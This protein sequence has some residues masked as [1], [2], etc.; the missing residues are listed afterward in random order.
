MPPTATLLPAD[1]A[2]PGWPACITF[3]I[4]FSGCTLDLV[5]AQVKPHGYP[6]STS[7]A[8]VQGSAAPLVDRRIALRLDRDQLHRP[9]DAER[10]GSLPEG[11]IRLDQQRPRPDHD[12]LPRL[13]RRR[14]A[15]RRPA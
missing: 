11:R 9:P 13:L 8:L 12:R 5:T 7:L 10:A 15:H 6:G 2:K 4:L 3:E 1:L 14:A